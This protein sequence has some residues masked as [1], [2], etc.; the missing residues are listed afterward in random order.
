MLVRFDV[1]LMI[2][3]GGRGRS[4]PPGTAR[5][6]PR[7]P[8][9]AGVSSPWETPRIARMDTAHIRVAPN[10]SG[11]QVFRR[12][13][14]TGSGVITIVRTTSQGFRAGHCVGADQHHTARQR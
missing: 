14:L 13:R 9:C 6:A 4:R 10:L 12:P 1:A 2:A 11:P 7:Y 8:L 5:L 3:P